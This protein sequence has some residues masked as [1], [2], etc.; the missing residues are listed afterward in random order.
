MD[1]RL[2]WSEELRFY[3]TQT[4]A[5]QL[6]RVQDHAPTT[7]AIIREGGVAVLG[8]NAIE[9]DAYRYQGFLRVT[10]DRW[11]DHEWIF[12]KDKL[13]LIRVWRIAPVPVTTTPV[14]TTQQPV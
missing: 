11:F 14:P 5:A 4:E 6:V 10:A 13:Y 9:I 7:N 8:P 1:L 3:Y 2:T 12:R